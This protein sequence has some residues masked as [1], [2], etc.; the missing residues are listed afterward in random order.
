MLGLVVNAF[1]HQNSK[2][3][4]HYMVAN[5]KNIHVDYFL[6]WLIFLFLGFQRQ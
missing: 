2:T 5:T 4:K 6:K 1:D 3:E